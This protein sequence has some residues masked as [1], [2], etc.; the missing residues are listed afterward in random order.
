VSRPPQQ[1]EAV[2]CRTFG[3]GLVLAHQSGHVT[4]SPLPTERLHRPLPPNMPNLQGHLP[5]TLRT[6]AA[7]APLLPRSRH[8]TRL[9]LVAAIALTV[10]LSG[11]LMRPR[12]LGRDWYRRAGLSNRRGSREA[13]LG[14]ALPRDDASILAPQFRQREMGNDADGRVKVR[15]DTLLAHHQEQVGHGKRLLQADGAPSFRPLVNGTDY[16]ADYDIWNV[17]LDPDRVA[18]SNATRYFRYI[19]PEEHPQ[20]AMRYV[21]N[22]PRIL[23]VQDF[24][25]PAECDAIIA[26]ASKALFRSLILQEPG[27][28]KSTIDDHRTSSQAWLETHEE[29]LKSITARVL[30]LT[31]FAIGSNELFQVVRYDEGQKCDPHI[32]YY[33]PKIFGERTENRAV[34]VFMYLNDVA[35]GGETHFPRA[36]GK[37]ASKHDYDAS[38]NRGLRVHPRKGQAVVF[39]GMA[40]DA[41]LD[42]SSLHGGCPVTKGVKWGGTQWLMVPTSGT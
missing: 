36:N 13:H 39:Y 5:H 11:A 2:A 34:T 15:D 40:P 30:A 14:Q 4:T 6:G 42:P 27:S 19:K 10:V 29:P 28:N 8:L 38:C 1:A 33:D 24:L 35:E 18:G 26:R 23:L 31:G 25:S 9:L 41:R 32:D 22:R 7:G 21:S 16:F 3:V 37:K 17:R 20:Y 12:G